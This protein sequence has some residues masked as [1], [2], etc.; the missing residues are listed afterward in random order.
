M[1]FKS[2][3]DKILLFSLHWCRKGQTSFV[4]PKYYESHNSSIN[5]TQSSLFPNISTAKNS[6]S[7]KFHVEHKLCFQLELFI[8]RGAHSLAS[9]R[10]TWSGGGGFPISLVLWSRKV[11]ATIV[12]NPHSCVAICVAVCEAQ[13]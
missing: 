4:Y 13:S 7:V 11:P 9:S 1:S 10:Q 6:T 5:G 12:T 8:D 2:Y 3:V